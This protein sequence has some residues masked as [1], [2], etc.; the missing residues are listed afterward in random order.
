MRT[1]TDSEVLLR[2]VRRRSL[3]ERVFDRLSAGIISGQFSAGTPLPSE[4]KLCESFGVN[5]GALREALKRLEQSGL[6]AIQQG[7]ATRVLDYRESA[8]LDVISHLVMNQE[9]RV[10]LQ[11]ARSMIE[12]RAA[13]AP[14]VV[15][16]AANRQG[17]D[18]APSLS[19]LLAEM[20]SN[21]DD[22]VRA[23]ELNAQFW[24]IVVKASDNI[25]YVLVFN[26]IE[27]VNERIKHLLKPLLSTYYQDVAGFEAMIE[28]ILSG[29]SEEARRATERHVSRIAD[30]LAGKVRDLRASGATAWRTVKP[31]E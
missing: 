1:T 22:P 4:R 19:P 20:R 6:I 24:R 8:G 30:A 16:L 7:G 13:I 26:T 28:P 2:P 31:S 17:A 9:G 3:S 27:E 15:R 25:A 29:E 10:D 11:V 14:D 5:R 18:L 23:Q 21:V 12:L